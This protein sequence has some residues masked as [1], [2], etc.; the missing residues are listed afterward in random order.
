VV[1]I[2]TLAEFEA[3]G[4]P[5]DRARVLAQLVGL[6]PGVMELLDMWNRG[7][8]TE[9]AVEHGIREGHTKTKWTSALKELRHH[10]LSPTDVAG[11]R[12]RGWIDKAEADRLGLLRGASSQT[13][14]YL[15]LNRGRP[16][17]AHQIHVGFAR[18]GRHP[19]IGNDEKETIRAAVAQSDIRPEWFDLLWAQRYTMPSAFVLRA[20]TQDGTFTEGQ[21]ENVLLES[22]WRPDLAKAAAT[23]WAG[24][25]AGPSTKWA[26]RA[27]GYI[28]TAAH[29]DYLDGNAD[30]PDARAML[31]AVGAVGAEQ[32]SIIS[33]WNLERA[34][35]RKDLTQAQILKLFRKNIW[36]QAQAHAALVDLGMDA[37]DADDL[38]QAG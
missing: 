6:P 37:G 2:D 38:L 31:A 36:P 33:L 28:F 4:V 13:M 9:T 19:T 16:A 27:R 34:R 10:L 8:I 25:G 1:G 30:E 21:A 5:E 18:G 29:G 24:S 14:E 26:D 3:G 12:L 15:Y 7:V 23:K 20:L 35:T 32:D 17:T 11:L 22:G